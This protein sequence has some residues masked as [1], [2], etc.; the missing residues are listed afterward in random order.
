M[1]LQIKPKKLNIRYFPAFLQVVRVAATPFLQTIKKAL[2]EEAM[3]ARS[4]ATP[5]RTEVVAKADQAV[6]AATGS[7]L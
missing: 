5:G 7:E 3:A 6:E 1:I 2:Q 4:S